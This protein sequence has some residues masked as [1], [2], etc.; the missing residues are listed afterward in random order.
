MQF[1]R[2]FNDFIEM[3]YFFIFAMFIFM[4]GIH[5]GW[6]D[7]FQVSSYME[8]QLKSL[9]GISEFINNKENPQMWLILVIFINNTIKG[10]LVIFLGVAFGVIPLIMLSTN[11]L[12]LGYVLSLET[13]LSVW[14]LIL[15]G[16]IP[17][18]IIE[19]P[20]IWIACAYGIKLGFLFTMSIIH[21]LL[22]RLGVE[23]WN[24]FKKTIQLT[25]TLAVCLTVCFAIAAVIESTIS[26]WLMKNL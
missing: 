16:I 13:N 14:E 6:Y 8:D 2:L 19:I 20:A 10:V 9:K 25:K 1:K 11:G 18:G 15:K 24:D 23:A 4:F 21:K 7:S 12:L 5:A 3:K 17:H 22:P 26:Y